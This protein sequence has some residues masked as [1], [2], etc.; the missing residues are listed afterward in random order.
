LRQTRIVGARFV[1]FVPVLIGAKLKKRIA[2]L[3]N[4]NFDAAFAYVFKLFIKK[5]KRVKTIQ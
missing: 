1:S 4:F 3:Y 2:T 5:K